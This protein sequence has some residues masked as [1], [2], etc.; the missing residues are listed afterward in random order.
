MKLFVA[1]ALVATASPV[2][3]TTASA[4]QDSVSQERRYCTQVSA[5]RAGS[6]MSPRR[7]CR[8]AAQW[9][10]ALGPDWRQHLTGRNREDDIAA[11]QARAS[12]VDSSGL[13]QQGLPIGHPGRPAIGPN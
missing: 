11:M 1:V 12:P 7:I 2:L 10:E 3:A 5:A 6:R 13:G 8:T 4:E 9:Q